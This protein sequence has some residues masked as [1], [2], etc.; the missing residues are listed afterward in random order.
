MKV[1]TILGTRPEIIRLSRIIP[2]LDDNCEHVLVHT[3]QNYNDSLNDVFFNELKIRRPDYCF[4]SQSKTA[5][6]QI[7]KILFECEKII[8]KEENEYP[9]LSFGSWKQMF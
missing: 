2:L 5:M 6:E 7:G 3:G 1:M 8:L 4:E 9:C